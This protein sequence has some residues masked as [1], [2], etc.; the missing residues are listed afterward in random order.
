MFYYLDILIHDFILIYHTYFR[1]LDM[2]LVNYLQNEK[3]LSE[4][5]L[6]KAQAR[7][8]VKCP[9]IITALTKCFEL[10]CGNVV[11]TNKRYIQQ[12]F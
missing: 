7:P 12:L 8:P 6:K 5:D 2:K 4:A 3:K 1:P 9:H 11:P 10:A